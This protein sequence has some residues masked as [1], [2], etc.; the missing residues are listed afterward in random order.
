MV[1][2]LNMGLGC[3]STQARVH[4]VIAERHPQHLQPHTLQN[5]DL[6]FKGISEFWRRLKMMKHLDG[7]MDGHNWCG[8]PPKDQQVLGMNRLSCDN[9]DVEQ[10]LTLTAQPD[11]APEPGP[12]S[13][14]TGHSPRSHCAFL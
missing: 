8:H 3:M 14:Q 4:L 7:A 2:K 5:G 1:R 9:G 12:V 6:P 10:S 13:L 11:E